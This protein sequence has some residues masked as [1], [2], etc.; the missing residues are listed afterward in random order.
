MPGV[1]VHRCEP[2]VNGYHVRALPRG[3]PDVL[4]YA[5]GK[6]VPVEWKRDGDRPGTLSKE[7]IRVHA[8]MAEGGVRVLM[9]YSPRDCCRDLAAI[10][11]GEVGKRLLILAG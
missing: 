8:A 6:I 3:Y 11:G 7:Q 4:F 2:M 5:E 10:I 9:A 1:Y